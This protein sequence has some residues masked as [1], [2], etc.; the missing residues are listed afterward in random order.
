M[1]VSG[2]GKGVPM[3]RESAKAPPA[4]ESREHP[5]NRQMATLATVYSVDRFV[6]TPQEIIEALF[7]KNT[8]QPRVKRPEPVGKA[9]VGYLTRIDE[10]GNPMPGDIQAFSWAGEQVRRRHQV[11]QPLVRLMDG[12]VSLWNTATLCLGDQPTVDI[13]DIIHVSSYV[14]SAAK[15]FHS[16]REYQEAFTQERLHRIL[17][18]EVGG[19]I[20]GLR[21]MATKHQLSKK[22]RATIERICGYFE[23]NRYRM[24]VIM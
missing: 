18:G 14:W 17:C 5:G 11:G 2:D 20:S 10:D 9:V 13:L 19:V 22:D 3:V 16:H 23:R 1:R 12:Q 6:R 4:F 21:Q 8:E 24:K 7:R 15:V